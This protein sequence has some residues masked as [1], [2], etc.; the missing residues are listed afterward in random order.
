[1]HENQPSVGAPAEPTVSQQ[2][3]PTV[4]ETEDWHL[5]CFMEWRPKH[6]TITCPTCHGRGEV[7]GIFKDLDGPQTCPECWGTNIKSVGP[8]TPAPELP[9]EL[10][11]HMRRAWWDYLH[12]G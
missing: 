3:S 1:M 2:S 5:G 4:V 12:A 9:A 6:K 10:R 11:E 7:G 8:T